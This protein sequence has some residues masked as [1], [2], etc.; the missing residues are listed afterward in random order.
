MAEVKPEN[1]QSKRA[2][3][4]IKHPRDYWT[5]IPENFPPEI[6]YSSTIVKLLG[7]ASGYLG[8]LGGIGRQLPN[9]YV[10]V[11]PAIR[12]EAVL[13]SRIEGTLSGMDDLF[14]FEAR[15]QGKP[16]KL[17]AREV[18]NYVVAME[19]GLSRLDSLPVSFRFTR[20]LH[21][22]LMKGVRGQQA[23]PGEFR[24]TQNW[25]GPPGC[26]LNEAT[27]VPPPPEEMGDLLSSWEHYIHDPQTDVH[28]LIRLGVIHAQFE[29]IHPFADGNGRIG[30]LLI[31]L[32]MCHWEL[33]PQ[34]LLYLS[35]FFERNR[36]GYYQ[37][38]L[39]IS[40]HGAWEEWIEFFL[41]GTHEQSQEALT[42]ARALIDL[43]ARYR[44][45]L[46]GE[47]VPLVTY[48][49]IDR[50]FTNPVITVP[51]IR[52]RWNINFHTAQRAIDHLERLGILREVTGQR[53]Y[54]AWVAETI[55]DILTGSTTP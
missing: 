13:S 36:D 45:V 18:H 32:L 40:Q 48:S 33:L 3:R 23:T 46:E 43:N 30:R 47:R 50:L 28:N 24:T 27:Y 42:S 53:R 19:H 39:D 14:F 25:I 20:E 37:H 5:F 26:T 34:P 51:F 21:E 35:A 54:R 16:A 41:Q 52:D 38:L 55:M 1:Y 49:I 11:G 9:P 15:P 2:G 7:D 10:L 29:L 17:D 22:H 8:E 31:A 6:G 12:R 44:N 4:V